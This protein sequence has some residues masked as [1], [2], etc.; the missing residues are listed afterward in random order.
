M[1]ND[2]PSVLASA[3]LVQTRPSLNFSGLDRRFRLSVPVAGG[4]STRAVAWI[5]LVAWDE[6]SGEWPVV[7][8]QLLVRGVVAGLLGVV[9]ACGEFRPV[10][11]QRATNSVSMAALSTTFGPALLMRVTN[12]PLRGCIR[13]TLLGSSRVDGIAIRGVA[14]LRA[15]LVRPQGTTR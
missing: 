3:P 7:A 11:V 1:P 2:A 9:Q 12:N 15:E 14:P 5:A 4:Q 8:D 13:E 10:L 6:L